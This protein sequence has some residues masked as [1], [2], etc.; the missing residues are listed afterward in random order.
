MANQFGEAFKKAV[1]KSGK[2]DLSQYSVSDLFPPTTQDISHIKIPRIPTKDGL[3]ALPQ[4]VMD[5]FSDP[6]NIAA[7]KK[8]MGFDTKEGT[9]GNE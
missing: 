7:A 3:P 5:S 9:D 1:E 8:L 4:E 6:E 2:K